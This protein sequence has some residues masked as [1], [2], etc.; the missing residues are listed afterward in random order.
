MA[1]VLAVGLNGAIER[2]TTFRN[3]HL[4]VMVFMDKFSSEVMDTCPLVAA[5]LDI[6][7]LGIAVLANRLL[8]MVKVIS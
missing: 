8:E 4:V 7:S 5:L 2:R 1:R 3:H 6:C